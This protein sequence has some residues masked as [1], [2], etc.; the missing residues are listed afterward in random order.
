MFLGTDIPCPDCKPFGRNGTRQHLLQCCE[1]NYSGTGEDHAECPECG[2]AFFISYKVDSVTR[3]PDFDGES[4]EEREQYE[5][6]RKLEEQE[7]EVEELARLAAK[8]NCN[9]SKGN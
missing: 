4:R 3:C 8:Y 5:I 2:H 7:K 9:I 6:K 1:K